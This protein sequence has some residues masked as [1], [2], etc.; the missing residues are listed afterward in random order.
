MASQ[1]E[2][3]RENEMEAG[4]SEQSTINAPTK[5]KEV[6]GDNAAAEELNDEQPA[7][8]YPH[9][10]VLAFIII[11]IIFSVFLLALDQVSNKIAQ[12]PPK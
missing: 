7:D 9:G 10:V 6:E 12:I 8:E 2:S 4:D 11:A 3:D 1:T 5:E